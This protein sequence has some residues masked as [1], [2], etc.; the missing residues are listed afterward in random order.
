MKKVDH[1]K[2]L[3][4][5][6]W[7]VDGKDEVRF[8]AN[9][10]AAIDDKEVPCGVSGFYRLEGP[11]HRA[12]IDDIIRDREIRSEAF[13]KKHPKEHVEYIKL[14]EHSEHIKLQEGFYVTI[15]DAQSSDIVEICELVGQ[16]SP[17]VPHDY[18][19]AVRKFETHIL[20][21]PDYFLWVA[22]LDGEI[23]GTAMMHLQHKLSYRCGTAAH[24]ED[25]VVDK[26]HRSKG[27]GQ[28][29]L[30]R[31]KNVAQKHGC[32]KLMLTCQMRTTS[33]YKKHGFE[34]HDHGMRMTLLDELYEGDSSA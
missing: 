27:I 15:R 32:Y 4:I 28:R 16:L 17:G 13:K 5:K 19:E 18:R 2:T 25:L 3:V 23:V 34:L 31:A 9:I 29:F 6:T 21:S 26:S 10:Y 20:P 1:Q 24:L 22:E 8:F 30:T 7:P 11:L 33:F 14:Q 12:E